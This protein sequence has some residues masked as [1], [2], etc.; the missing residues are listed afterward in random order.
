MEILEFGQAADKDWWLDQIGKS[1][2]KAGK[3]LYGLLA[4]KSFYKHCGMKSSLFLL[5][6]G[7]ELISFC[8]LAEQDEVLDSGLSPWI[9]FVYTFPRYR[10]KRRIGKLIERA[11]ATAKKEE[12][13]SIYV[14]T[15]QK[16]LYENF[17]FTFM[18]EM[19][20]RWSES[21]LIY[22]KNIET[23]DYGG[24]LGREVSGTIDRPL[25]SPHPRHPEMIY[26]VNYGYVD[27]VIAGDGAEQD[28]YLLGEDKPVPRFTGKVIA[29][30]HRLNDVEDKWIVSPDGRTYGAE[31]IA[32]A[33]E[34]QEQYFI[35]EL[36]MEP[37]S[38][39]D[40]GR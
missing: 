28:V 6:E 33:I 3:Y 17:G 30:L 5:T 40:G 35:G 9:G 38:C 31:E 25:G 21:T 12:Y 29:V 32:R 7:R 23:P 22:K 11:Y 15:D 36:Y 1:D 2:W 18:Q 10:G 27:G 13:R 8:T 4:D 37:V 24:I 16:G 14:S 20:N 26:P 34:F 39:Q 19:K